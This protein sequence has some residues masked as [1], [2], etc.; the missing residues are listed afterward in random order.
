MENLMP[1]GRFSEM[2]RLS[3]KALRHY[4][5]L[6]LLVPAM[7]DRSS[8]YRYYAHAQAGRAEAIR[9]LR[10]LDMP[11]DEIREVVDA[12]DARAA[13]EALDRHRTRLQ[14]ALGRHERMLAYLGKLIEREEGV[15]YEI[16][17][18]E[19]PA[20]HVAALRKH[21]TK[22]TI[23]Q[24]VSSGFA[25]VGEAVGRSGLPMV[26]PPFLIMFDVLDEETGA[27]IEIAFPVATPFPGLGDVVGEE[28]AATTVA[29]AVHRGPYDE[30]GPAY[31]KLAGWIQEHGHEV[32]GPPRE[33]YLTDPQE[34]P[35]PADYVT[36]IQ[37]PIR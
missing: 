2:T 1:I 9:M 25:A 33:I 17:V 15:M 27:D 19:V 14:A 10:S 30:I 11:L 6:G 29:S 32:A 3:V 37:F 4:D 34:T 36:E 22:A 7:V 16:A 5:E 35:D 13:A 8:G 20:Q 21:A 31:H 12:G 18:K 23:G 26:G 28:L 24:D